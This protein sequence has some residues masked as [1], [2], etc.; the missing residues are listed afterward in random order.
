V[1]DK[2]SAR[3]GFDVL[4]FVHLY[5]ETSFASH[6]VDRKVVNM[7]MCPD[8]TPSWLEGPGRFRPVSGHN[9]E[10]QNLPCPEDLG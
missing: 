10:T 4:S 3:G 8:E 1:P 6:G 2:T 5:D 9:D 7:D